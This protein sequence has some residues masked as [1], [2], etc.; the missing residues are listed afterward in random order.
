MEAGF[1]DREE[2]EGGEEGEEEQERGEGSG[3]ATGRGQG[4]R[5]VAPKEVPFSHPN[6]WTP[7]APEAPRPNPLAPY[8]SPSPPPP[9]G[10]HRSRSRS[11]GATSLR[12]PPLPLHRRHLPLS[13]PAACRLAA[14]FPPLLLL[15]SLLAVLRLLPSPPSPRLPAR[16][17]SRPSTSRSMSGRWRGSGTRSRGRDPMSGPSR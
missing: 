10:R 3:E 17:S 9:P 5:E 16:V 15:L 6:P 11:T 4:Q 1:G 13:L 2:A 14:A 8:L 12:S 7:A